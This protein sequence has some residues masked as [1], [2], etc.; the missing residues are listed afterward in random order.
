MRFGALAA[1]SI[2][3]LVLSTS[4]GIGMALTGFGYWALV[5]ATLSS[6]AI[7]MF[8]L[9]VATG[10]IPGK[11]E[12]KSGVR[13]ML[14]YGGAL[15]LNGLVVYL[16]TNAD[17]VLLGR[18]WGAEALGIYGRAYQLVNLPTENLFSTI[19]GVAFPALSRLQ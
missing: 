3:A 2:V 7:N 6:A 4:V 18:V 19:G 11:P 16:T 5:G 15:T 10:W 14:K 9:W 17:K 8:A 12:R 13:S 1:I